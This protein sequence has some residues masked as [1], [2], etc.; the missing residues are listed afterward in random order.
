MAVRATTAVHKLT[1]HFAAALK[2]EPAVRGLW[3]RPVRDY[4]EFWLL[5]EPI[6]ADAERRLYAAGTDLYER[7]PDANV[8]VRILNPRLFEPGDLTTL[9]PSDAQPVPL[10]PVS[11]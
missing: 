8:R 4:V 10:Q 1:R 2:A 7:F 9:I 6:D 11:R 3:V 5:T